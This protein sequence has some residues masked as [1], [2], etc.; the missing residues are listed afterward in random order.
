[1]SY[2]NFSCIAI[3]LCCAL[4]PR[5]VEEGDARQSA[6]EQGQDLDGARVDYHVRKR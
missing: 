2:V 1:M 6:G 4:D 5:H 3:L